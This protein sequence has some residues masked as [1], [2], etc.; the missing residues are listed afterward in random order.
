MA[1]T[2]LD[3]NADEKSPT[4]KEKLEI[5]KKRVINKHKKTTERITFQIANISFKYYIHISGKI[6]CSVLCYGNSLCSSLS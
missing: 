1:N 3:F 2:K 4:E 6:L 5:E